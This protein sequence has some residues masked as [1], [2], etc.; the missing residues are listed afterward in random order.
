MARN[1]INRVPPPSKFFGTV[2]VTQNPSDD[3]LNFQDINNA[4]D[5]LVGLPESENPLSGNAFWNIRLNGGAYI[6][7]FDLPVNVGLVGVGSIGQL[8]IGG[9]DVQTDDAVV[10]IRN[11]SLSNIIIQPVGVSGNPESMILIKNSLSVYTKRQSDWTLPLDGTELKITPEAQA[12]ESFVFTAT[13]VDAVSVAAFIVAN[14]IN[15]TAV[16]THNMVEIKGKAGQPLTVNKTGTANVRLGFSTIVDEK[17]VANE[18]ELLV[19]KSILLVGNSAI[20][21]AV[22]FTDDGG[23]RYA[24]ADVFSGG[25]QYGI[26]F[27]D[28][29]S[30]ILRNSF[31]SLH[32]TAGVYLEDNV[33]AE[34]EN[35]KSKL[36]G[37][38]VYIGNNSELI[39]RSFA[40]EK[41]TNNGILTP[42]GS[43]IT[44]EWNVTGVLGVGTFIDG[45]RAIPYDITI[46]SIQFVR[47]NNGTAG[48]TI[49]DINYGPSGG[50]EITLYTNQANRP[51]VTSAEGDNTVK[52]AILPDI[53]QIPKGYYLSMDIDQVE[54]GG[55]P[56]APSDLYVTLTGVVN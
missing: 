1:N 16:A 53:V 40:Y 24:M 8:I 43:R 55:G 50:G 32:A 31:P 27:E 26:Y 18:F 51:T 56:L 15:I 21:K 10:S 35:G 44:L 33:L 5:Y 42:S 34:F 3:L 23:G 20:D 49:I 11:G 38:D 41:I 30:G 12:Q 29:S 47:R 14:G 19:L 4:I 48:S 6:Q 13:E 22:N 54:G 28:G 39:A 9:S 36:N 52:L 17:S 7:R 46:E 45:P 37:T 25:S 2:D